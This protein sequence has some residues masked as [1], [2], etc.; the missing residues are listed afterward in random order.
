MALKEKMLRRTAQIAQTVIQHSQ[1][2]TLEDEEMVQGC[3][4]FCF[5]ML[6]QN[7]DYLELAYTIY[8]TFIEKLNPKIQLT[9]KMI[10]EVIARHI[11]EYSL[12]KANLKNEI[13]ELIVDNLLYY[14]PISAIIRNAGHDLNDIIINT[15]DYIDVIY[16]GQTIITPFRFRSEMELRRIINRM[17]SE[18]NRKIDESHPIASAKLADGSRIEVQI[19]PVAAN[20]DREGKPGSY[21]TIRKFREI[22]LLFESMLDGAQMDL[23]IAYFLLK[24]VQGKLNIVVSGGTSSG[25]T[26]F[27]NAITRFIDEGDQLLTIED[28]KEMKPQ[29]PCHSIRSFE[30]RMENEEGVG[31][32]TIE[33]L[34][35]TALRSSPRRIIV[36][37]CRGPEIVT[38]LNAMNTG[39]PGSMTT[40]HADDTKEAIIRIE[41]MF[42]E[43]RPSANMTFV[44]SQIISAVDLVIQLVRFPDGRRRVVKISEPEKRM[45]ENGIVSMLDIFEFKRNSFNG[46]PTDSNGTF[47]AV[48][49]PV[50]SINKM[51]QNGVEIEKKI[52]DPDFIVTKD[53]L[54]GELKSFHPSRM[55]GWEDHYLSEIIK[56]SYQEG[57]SI[58]E[59]WPNLK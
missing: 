2:I 44:R 3:Q 18:S 6:Y 28:T 9:E 7:N 22:P 13:I 51:A 30:A 45:E 34:L 40:V 5:P 10:R 8:D 15:K 36:G 23:K 20:V 41:N 46:N 27:L 16:G 58:L 14:G 19:P 39:H 37:E 52:F 31:A 32:I 1:D 11:A 59:R 29:M 38:M 57:K 24:A 21:V 54:I 25:K 47:N 42:L 50:R 12:P 55:C 56:N 17:L 33:Q 43:A 48:S 49:A 35:R 53:M 26:T 4:V